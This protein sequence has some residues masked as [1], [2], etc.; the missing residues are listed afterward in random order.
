MLN[1][2]GGQ[3][4]RYQASTKAVM[5][6]IHNVFILHGK[7]GS[8]EGSSKQIHKCLEQH[9]P[10]LT[11]LISR[12]L[13]LHSDPSLLAEDSLA[14]LRN[15]DI[16]DNS[17]V[18]GISLGGLLAAKLQES[19]RGDLYVIC[20]SSP[21]WA[22]G[23]NLECMMANRISYF[24]SKDEVILGRTARWPQLAKAFDLPWLSHDTDR[25]KEALT[26][27][28]VAQIRGLESGAAH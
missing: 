20:I 22:D 23:V 1:D 8:P 13:L 14:D 10:E 9:L 6:A 3:P 25:H 19:G 26:K 4:S 15:R 21:T 27:L 24:S 16:P 7:G 18:I 11:G 2:S 28:I 17:V 12:P 5:T